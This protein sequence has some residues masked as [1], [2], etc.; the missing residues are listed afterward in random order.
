MRINEVCFLCA[1]D[2]WKLDRSVDD[3]ESKRSIS[4]SDAMRLLYRVL[5]S[6]MRSSY[7]HTETASDSEDNGDCRCRLRQIIRLMLLLLLLLMLM[8]MMMTW[9]LLI[10]LILWAWLHKTKTLTT[11]RNATPHKGPRSDVDFW[12]PIAVRLSEFSVSSE[13]NEMKWKPIRSIVD[14]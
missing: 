7:V 11:D 5:I 8:M 13:M 14:K 1:F 2:R 4:S 10:V 3:N 12:Q 6:Y 9:N